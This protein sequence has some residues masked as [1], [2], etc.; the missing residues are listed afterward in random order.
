MDDLKKMRDFTEKKKSN[1]SI[2]RYCMK[3][4]SIGVISCLICFL[5]VF[6][7]FGSSINSQ[8]FSMLNDQG[9]SFEEDDKYK[10]NLPDKKILVDNLIDLTKEEKEAVKKSILDKNPDLLKISEIFVDK[11]GDVVI[12]YDDGY[13][14]IVYPE[15]VISSKTSAKKADLKSP[16][17]NID[18][19][20]IDSISEEEIEK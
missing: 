3:K 8:D 19:E 6:T 18:V 12:N 15:D 9:F 20:G 17:N 11:N 1:T 4:L 7:S 2:S 5:T 16:K 13:E 10:I 14:K